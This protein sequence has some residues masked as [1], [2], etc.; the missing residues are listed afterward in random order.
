VTGRRREDRQ[1]RSP[2][3]RPGG[4]GE[5]GGGDMGVGDPVLVFERLCLSMKC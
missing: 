2:A 3:Y 5:M 1:Q 4:V